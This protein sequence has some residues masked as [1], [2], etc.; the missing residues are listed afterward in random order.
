[1]LGAPPILA[2]RH[3]SKSFG[4]T[5]ALNGV[6][7][8]FRAGDICGLVGENG[9]GKTTLV[10]ILL[11]IH[12]PDAGEVILRGKATSLG[13][14]ARA[15]ALGIVGVHQEFSLIP[16]SPVWENLFLGQ[17]QTRLG[18]LRRRNMRQAAK[19]SLDDLASIVPLDSKVAELSR[20][21]QQQVEIC[22]ALVRTSGSG[23]ILLLD[24][25]TAS[26][27]AADARQLFSLVRRCRDRGM[28][29]IYITHR[30]PEIIELCER[31]IVLRN[32]AIASER[33]V[34]ET[35]EQQLISDMTGHADLGYADLHRTVPTGRRLLGVRDLVTDTAAGV[36]LAV[37]AGEIVG[38][39]GSVGSGAETVIDAVIGIDL[40]YAGK[41]EIL[42]RRVSRPTPG[43]ARKMGVAVIPQ[44]RNR[45]GLF[46]SRSV[47]D[48]VTMPGLGQKLFHAKLGLL[49]I[50][51]IKRET[52]H[53]M[54]RLRFPITNAA[55]RVDSLSGGQQQKV[56][57]GRALVTPKKL[58]LLQDP[59]VGVDVAT[60]VDIY[61]ALKDLTAEGAGVLVSSS[62]FREVA[63]LCDRV[64]VFY[65]GR[66][67]AEYR[68][69]D[70]SESRILAAAVGGAKGEQP[71]A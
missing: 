66:I 38:L 45:N 43:R 46:A 21:E 42:G 69:P 61:R 40:P 68:R 70:I 17:E 24:E 2:I 52:S 19:R 15:R 29:V 57:I 54:E 62:D 36:T 6:D 26:L 30:L 8:E 23:G 28:A 14:P 47:A 41:I 1:M 63:E 25:P 67:A 4:S 39:A 71:R 33:L 16:S 56:L 35:S 37:D 11:G 59:T 53:A 12:Q 65:G 18:I 48:N 64:Y 10:N 58:F 51:R 27:A 31:V 7:C 13:S 60:R 50:R 22:K 5:V 9:A 49:S 55:N 34:C 3:I 44:D 20:A 32:G